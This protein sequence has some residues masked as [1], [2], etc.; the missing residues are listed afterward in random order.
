MEELLKAIKNIKNDNLKLLLVGGDYQDSFYRKLLLIGEN[1][2]IPVGEK[3]HEVMPEYLTASDMV[4]LPQRETLFANAQVP[5]KVFEAMAMEKPII[6]TN[7]SD[8]K[9]ILNSCGIIIDPIKNT[10]ELEI[11]I[12][13]LINDDKLSQ[14]LGKKARIK[15]INE[16]SW[17]RMAEKLFPIFEK[18]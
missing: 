1:I 5:A 10:S 9:E 13:L 11:K 8:M 7:I 18:L 4:V 16:Y 17:E 14:S 2:I 3:D 6:S 12:K 15:C